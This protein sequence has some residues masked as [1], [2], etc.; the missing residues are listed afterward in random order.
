M[1]RNEAISILKMHLLDDMNTYDPS[2]GEYGFGLLNAEKVKLIEEYEGIKVKS[3]TPE[4]AVITL[5]DHEFELYINDLGQW[6]I[7]QDTQEQSKQI[8]IDFYTIRKQFEQGKSPMQIG[9]ELKTLDRKR[10]YSIGQYSERQLI[11]KA[12]KHNEQLE[13]FDN[14]YWIEYNDTLIPIS[15]TA[16][17]YYEFI[18]EKISQ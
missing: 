11:E 9:R 1:T 13:Y 14:S 10:S 17:K 3:Y 15:K 7:K 6:D 12:I 4:T 8:Y 5:D 2:V 16:A 18:K